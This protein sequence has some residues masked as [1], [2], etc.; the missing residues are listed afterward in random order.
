MPD[1][2]PL[3][4][5]LLHDNGHGTRLVLDQLALVLARLDA[6]EATLA[7]QDDELLLA[8][9]AAVGR[10]PFLAA[11]V[12]R[13]AAAAGPSGDELRRLLPGLSAKSLGKALARAAR[14]P[15]VIRLDSGSGRDGFLWRLVGG[16]DDEK[17]RPPERE[18]LGAW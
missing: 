3:D 9:H 6:I 2:P 13:F 4:P 10:R 5:L 18:K 17:S 1:S 12:C 7:S 11:E 8:V 16:F 15:G 14:R